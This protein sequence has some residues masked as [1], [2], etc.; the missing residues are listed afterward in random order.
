MVLLLCS[1]LGYGHTNVAEYCDAIIA[2]K[3]NLF[4][5]N[6]LLNLMTVDVFHSLLH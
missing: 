6:N 2:Y 5:Y 4:C 3:G 1:A